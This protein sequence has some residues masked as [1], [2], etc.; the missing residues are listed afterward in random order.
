MASKLSFSSLGNLP[1]QL[2][3]MVRDFVGYREA[4]V[5]LTKQLTEE[6]TDFYPGDPGVVLLEAMSYAAGILSYQQDRAQNESYLLTAQQ[7]SN[8]VDILRLIGYELS[9]GA[10]ASVSVEVLTDKATVVLPAGWSV[11]SKP[12]AQSDAMRFE[13]AQAV[14]LSAAGT[15]VVTLVHGET[16]TDEGAGVTSGK[17]GQRV[18][19]GR[20]PLALTPGIADPVEVSVGGSIWSPVQTFIEQD[21]SAK[22]FRYFVDEVGKTTLEFGD[23]TNGKIP[24]T[25]QSIEVTYR[26]GG[27]KAANSVGRGTLTELPGTVDG[28]V[29]ASNPA[30]PSSG[31]DPESIKHAKAHGPLSLRALDRAVELGDFETLAVQTPSA[32]IRMAKASHMGSAYEVHV[33]VAAEGANPVPTGEWFPDMKA[34][35]GVIGEVGRYLT[36]LKVG[37]ARLFV[38]GPV[39]VRPYLKAHITYQPGIRVNDV[40]FYVQE[41][42]KKYFTDSG[43]TF[44]DAIPE[45]DIIAVVEGVRG[46]YKINVNAFHH[47]PALRLV[48]GHRDLIDGA[49]ITVGRAYDSQVEDEYEVE[50]LNY[51]RFKMFSKNYGKVVDA[52]G[53]QRLFETGNTYTITQY[54][55]GNDPRRARELPQFDFK[56]TVGGNGVVPQ[57][58]N[59]FSFSTDN[60]RGD[61][62]VGEFAMVVPTLYA[63]GE[64]D[65]KEFVLSYGGRQ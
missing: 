54:N 6:W 58:G 1:I 45:S 50:W 20:Q 25:G 36:S 30:Q 39:I 42:L 18:Q 21:Y 35:H 5:E 38:E 9:P 10:A 43:A 61:I 29:S 15:H 27:G 24:V 49:S 44:G 13:L 41:A 22:V 31:A 3:P 2:D 34:G 16:V 60:F 65:A 59:K 14:V 53:V 63:T 33:F 8:V 28:V 7:R 40:S 19:L 52:Q 17:A 56:I 57:H 4:L 55:S 11:E 51:V 48:T 26:V 32:G 47:V 46:V 12:S 62:S 37:G 64:L 23:G